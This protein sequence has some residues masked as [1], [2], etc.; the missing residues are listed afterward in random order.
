MPSTHLPFTDTHHTHTS[1]HTHLLHLVFHL[2]QVYAHVVLEIAEVDKLATALEALVLP[3]RM[4]HHVLVQTR[5]VGESFAAV[6]ADVVV[7]TLVSLMYKLQTKM[8]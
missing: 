4:L 5:L 2:P 7:L 3:V 6:V 8:F 1:H